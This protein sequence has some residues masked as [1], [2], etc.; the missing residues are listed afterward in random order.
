MYVETIKN[1]PSET[2]ATMPGLL[3]A[4]AV[5]RAL[6][7]V[8]K[9]VVAEI[10]EVQ[11]VDVD[12]IRHHVMAR[13]EMQNKIAN[14]DQL[15]TRGRSALAGVAGMG[16]LKWFMSDTKKMTEDA[17]KLMNAGQIERTRVSKDVELSSEVQAAL[18]A[19]TLRA[20]TRTVTL[21]AVKELDQ[22]RTR[23]ERGEAPHERLQSETS[24]PVNVIRVVN[25]AREIAPISLQ[26]IQ[27]NQV[28]G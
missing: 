6:P 23:I 18:K 4:K 5:K 10:G 9:E 17:H 22:V 20:Q 24:I 2:L 14:A 19:Q 7:Q 28:R 15:E 16:L 25:R 8:G 13:L 21:L 3:P 26:G 1:V 11:A 27:P 12:A